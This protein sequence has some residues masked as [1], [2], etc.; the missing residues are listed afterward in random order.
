LFRRFVIR[1]LRV[2]LF[3]KEKSVCPPKQ[4][5][6]RKTINKPNNNSNPPI[7]KTPLPNPNSPTAQY[8][9]DHMHYLYPTPWPSNTTART[10]T[11]RIMLSFPRLRTNR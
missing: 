1:K 4:Q 6:Q 2:Q 3:E 11:T 9:K 8:N 5:T 10:R 7:G